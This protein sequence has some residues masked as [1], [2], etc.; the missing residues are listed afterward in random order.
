MRRYQFIMIL[1]AFLL[2]IGI[3]LT[4]MAWLYAHNYYVATTGSDINSGSISSPWATLANAM[5]HAQPGDTILVRGGTYNDGEIWINFNFGMGG[6]NGKFVTIIAHRGEQP[7]FNNPNRPLIIETQ[8]VRVQ[9]LNFQNKFVTVRRD[10]GI[11]DHIEILDNVFTGSVSPVL[12]FSSDNGLVQGNTVNVSNTYSHGIYIL[13]GSNNIIRNN[14]ITGMKKYGIH[15]YDENKYPNEPF[16][17]IIKN[18]LI[19][20]NVVT[21]SKTSAGIIVSNGA[22]APGG[23]IIDHVSIRNNVII[24]NNGYG[25][26]IQYGGRNENIDIYHNVIYHNN[27]GVFINGKIADHIKIKN[28][29]LALNGQTNIYAAQ[30]NDLIVSH[31]LYWQ[32]QL[33]GTGTNDDNPVFGN[34]QFVD[35]EK[36]DFHLQ[37]DSPAIDAGINLGLPFIGS[38]PDIGAFEYGKPT[39]V[40]SGF[41]SLPEFFNLEQN[42]PNPFTPHT[43]ISFSLPVVSFVDL[44]IFNTYGQR[45]KTLTVGEQAA[46]CKNM[47]WDGADENGLQVTPGIYFLKLTVNSYSLVKKMILLR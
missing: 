29:I 22:D 19:E 1:L 16:P 37:S 41:L 45:I 7:I 10:A 23:I 47:S 30:V 20:G 14:F 42:Y 24:N 11:S 26:Y 12:Y 17:P 32:P 33:V 8:Y 31:N 44:S 28:N 27:G 38:A 9:G 21:G 15:V 13:H 46:G 5:R 2:L 39:S 3:P 35:T 18:L 25:I 40:K 34:P 6:A 43:E 36:G 4:P